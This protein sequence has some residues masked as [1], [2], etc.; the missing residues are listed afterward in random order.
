MI[1]RHTHNFQGLTHVEFSHQHRFHGVSSESLNLLGHVHEI[2][3]YTTKDAGHSHYYQIL[4]APA[5]DIPGGHIHNYQG[6]TTIYQ[7]HRHSVS[8][9]TAIPNILTDY[10]LTPRPEFTREEAQRIGEELGIAW[11]RS[12]FDVEQFRTGLNVELEHGRRSPQTNVT[13]DDPIITGK[14]ALAHLNEFP[15]Y[16]V[17]LTK[18]EQAAKAYWGK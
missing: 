15:D 3:G 11:N 16:Y 1:A 8:G 14:I 12:P 4:T 7:R 2:S 10:M 17:R 9:A 18:L 13:D 5:V 6:Y